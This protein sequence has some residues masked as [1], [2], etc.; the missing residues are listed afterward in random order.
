MYWPEAQSITHISV[1]VSLSDIWSVRALANFGLHFKQ[2]VHPNQCFSVGH[3]T[4]EGV[5]PRAM[6]SMLDSPRKRYAIYNDHPC[7]AHNCIVWFTVRRG[8]WYKLDFNALSSA[9]GHVH[10]SGRTNT[11]V[12]LHTHTHTDTQKKP[13]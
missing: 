4:F 1:T 2:H 12:G 9:R 3:L 13:Q 10:T 5:K 11:A 6:L 8:S 7:M